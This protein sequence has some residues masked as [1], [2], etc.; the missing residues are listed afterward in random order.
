MPIA[1]M[2]VTSAQGADAQQLQD[3]LQSI[4]GV[5]VRHATANKLVIVTDTDSRNQDESLWSTLNGI[6][7][8]GKVELV[9]Y[10]F[11]DIEG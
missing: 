6:D 4:E 11:E 10:N 3:K 9:F 8:I 7:E 2:I 5:E 1:S